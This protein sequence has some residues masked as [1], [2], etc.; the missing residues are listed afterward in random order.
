MAG[1]SLT[2]DD[3]WEKFMSINSDDTSSECDEQD[4]CSMD[5]NNEILS[6]DITSNILSDAPKS[7]DIYIS[8]KT[9]IAYLNQPIDLNSLFWHIP[10]AE[11]A[12]PGDYVIKKQMW[13]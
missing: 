3:E 5:F 9:K 7:S 8:T 2:I 1:M 13:G 4:I 10:V 11:Y 12:K 6:H